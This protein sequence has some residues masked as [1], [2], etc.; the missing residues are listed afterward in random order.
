MF[1]LARNF[2][3]FRCQLFVLAANLCVFG[4]QF[5][6]LFA[7]GV[8]HGYIVTQQ[9]AECA[10]LITELIHLGLILDLLLVEL[11]HQLFN[12]RLG[13]VVFCQNRI[14]LKLD[15]L[16]LMLLEL[17]VKFS[18]FRR[19]QHVFVIKFK[20]LHLVLSLY[21]GLFLLGNGIGQEHNDADQHKRNC[22]G[23]DHKDILLVHC[24][25]LNQFVELN[26][27]RDCVRGS[28]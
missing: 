9:A 28:S 22:G 6:V 16:I 3:D 17:G 26:G 19:H 13:I 8:N 14:I 23:Y 1:V 27:I 4:A 15:G 20:L 2:A 5:G 18:Q 12:A 25:F 7:Q 10:D 21:V 11:A 24:S